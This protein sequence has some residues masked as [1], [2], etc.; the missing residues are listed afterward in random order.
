M[1]S[2]LDKPCQPFPSRCAHRVYPSS[3]QSTARSFLPTFYHSVNSRRHKPKFQ[4]AIRSSSRLV[5]S[6]PRSP[7]R[8]TKSTTPRAYST[9]ALM[10]RL[11]NLTLLCPR[12]LAHL[13]HRPSRPRL[14][15]FFSSLSISTFTLC[16]ALGTPR[17][18]PG[19]AMSAA[20]S[21]NQG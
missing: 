14:R 15:R 7:P 10:P 2:L 3:P 18:G 1:L 16:A 21:T 12:D 6:Q 9:E 17:N 4:D 5:P 11:P 8:T 13:T 19:A 20:L